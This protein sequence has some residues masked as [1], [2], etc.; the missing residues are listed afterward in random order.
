[1]RRETVA[2]S[3]LLAHVW[4]VASIHL[5]GRLRRSALRRRLEPRQRIRDLDAAEESHMV[6]SGDPASRR[7]RE[8]SAELHA[9]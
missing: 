2:L 5:L 7:E 9:C 1:M 3:S 4:C 8:V 6:R